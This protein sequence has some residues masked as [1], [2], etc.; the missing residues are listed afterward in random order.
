MNGIDTNILVRYFADDDE[1]QVAA[2]RRFL[3]TLTPEDPGYVSTVTLLELWWV[4]RNSY[5]MSVEGLIRVVRLLLAAPYLRVE[6]ADEVADAVGLF[7]K[8]NADLHDHLIERRCTGAGCLHTMTFD[9][10]AARSAGMTL[11]AQNPSDAPAPRSVRT[12][13]TAKMIAAMP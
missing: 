12:P 9:R 3:S 2:A 7:L 5:G 8:G 10:K 4:L 6:H 13:S 1:R 11:V